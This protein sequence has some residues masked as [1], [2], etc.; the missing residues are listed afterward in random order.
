MSAE[1][2]HKLFLSND[3][4][5]QIKNNK[6]ILDAGMRLM[7]SYGSNTKNRKP[8]EQDAYM[9][10][11][12]TLLK[13]VSILK[14]SQGIDFSS[15]TVNLK[16]SKIYDPQTVLTIVRS[17]YEAFSNFN[18]IYIQSKS[19]DEL[20]LK[21]YLWVKVGLKYRQ[22]Y[23][24]EKSR[25]HIENDT[26][27]KKPYTSIKEKKEKEKAEIEELKDRIKTNS[28]FM[29][30]DIDSKDL[31]CK[32]WHREWKYSITGNKAVKLNWVDIIKHAVKNDMIDDQ[33]NYLSS[34]THPSNVS[35]FQ[36]A[37]MHEQSRDKDTMRIALT[38]SNFYIAF[39]I[40][41]FFQFTKMES[42]FKSLS[43]EQKVLINTYNQMFR[44]IN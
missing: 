38:W 39:L 28:C 26:E 44:Q 32:N 6:L 30:L 1:N 21:Y 19:I 9:L 42:F 20:L 24:T 10:F 25:K 34:N 33:Y 31:I 3:I 41:D 13:G 23:N 37:A 43:T 8:Y 22:K 15:E 18:N 5:E 36:F 12:M 4:E 29:N 27:F 17:Q 14:L 2:L 7:Y 11:Q 40:S 16:L 35:V